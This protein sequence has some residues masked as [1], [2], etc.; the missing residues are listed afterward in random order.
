MNNA[1]IFQ[2]FQVHIDDARVDLC[3]FPVYDTWTANATADAIDD[4]GF[5]FA[6]H[7]F[8]GHAQSAIE[9]FRNFLF[10]HTPTI[11]SKLLQEKKSGT[12]KNLSLWGCPVR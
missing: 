9:H 6:T 11:W 7:Y 5:P 2:L 4:P 1:V 12:G 8:N 10:I 3:H